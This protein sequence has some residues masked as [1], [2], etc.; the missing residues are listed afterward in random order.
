MSNVAA[1]TLESTESQSVPQ[2]SR[3][4]LQATRL[5]LMVVMEVVRDV[6]S[7]EILEM[8]VEA[9]PR[10]GGGAVLQGADRYILRPLHG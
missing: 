8:V 9:V 1:K 6:M 5:V 2:L 3:A 10:A 7:T 4:V